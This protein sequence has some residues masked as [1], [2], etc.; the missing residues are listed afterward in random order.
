MASPPL[1]EVVEVE[2]LGGAVL[3]VEA[4]GA[5]TSK[6]ALASAFSGA[7]PLVDHATLAASG[8]MRYEFVSP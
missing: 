5:T 4:P 1:F 7:G 3:R 6:G 8:V 2:L